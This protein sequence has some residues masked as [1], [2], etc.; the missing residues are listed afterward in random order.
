M[1]AERS[2]ALPGW[3]AVVLGA[4]LLL[5]VYGYASFVL[6]RGVDLMRHSS[7][8]YDMD[9]ARVVADVTTRLPAYRPAVHPLQ[10]LLLALPDVA[11]SSGSAC[12]SVSASPS[13]VLAAIGLPPHL[14]RASLR[15]G[16]GRS[17]TERQVD[18]AA[19]RV[20]EAVQRQRSE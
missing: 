11:V 6:P 15:F 1:S 3:L 12:A 20:I 16:L 18:L 7:G 4:S 13:H 19:R 10:K 14:A 2:R 5:S 9:V 17:T 8:I